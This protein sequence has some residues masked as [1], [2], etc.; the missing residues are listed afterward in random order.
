M[1]SRSS[2]M[3]VGPILNMPLFHSKS[4][5]TWLLFSSIKQLRLVIHHLVKMIVVRKRWFDYGG[6]VG[7]WLLLSCGV[8]GRAHGTITSAGRETN[9]DNEHNERKRETTITQPK[10]KDCFHC[11]LPKEK[12]KQK[13][14]KA[15]KGTNHHCNCCYA[16]LTKTKSS[17]HNSN[18]T[19]ISY[20]IA[21]LLV[22]L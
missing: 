11:H 1:W 12:T 15:E 16:L 7:K 3:M 13:S 19:F 21:C 18:L 6:L 10:V 14:L 17:F 4:W 8:F 20:T 2:W 5:L 9:T 22:R